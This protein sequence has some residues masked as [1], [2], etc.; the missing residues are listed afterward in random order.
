M[1]SDQRGVFNHMLLV[2]IAMLLL[3]GGFVVWQLQDTDE[4]SPVI[5]ESIPSQTQQQA[6]DNNQTSQPA[7]PVSE[8]TK[9][10]TAELRAVGEFT[11]SGTAERW[12]QDGLYMLEVIAELDQPPEGRFYEGWIVGPSVI[13]TGMLTDEG[14]GQ[15][16]NSFQSGESLFSYNKIIITL[17]TSANG[18]DDIPEDHA[19]EGSF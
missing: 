7:Q 13:S 1:K 12:E 6:Q 14:S 10:A 11:G 3:V 8:R 19:L 15:W 9:V 2:G 5:D 18:L 16:S 4:P 17:E